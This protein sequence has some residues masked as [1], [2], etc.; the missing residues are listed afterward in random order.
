[1]AVVE[2]ARE[3]GASRPVRL[4]EAVGVLTAARQVVLLAH[5]NPDADALG[6]ALALGLALHRRGAEVQ[7]S[8]G[9][10][11]RPAESL[12]DLD[13]D[14]LVVTADE[15]V[16]AP[17]LLVVL[18]T[19]SVDRLGPLADRATTAGTTLVIDHHVS[20]AGFGTHY[21]VD[22]RAEATAV[23][24]LHLLDAMGAPV[25][26][27]TARCLYAG[28][29]TDTRNF[30]AASPDTHAMAAR[31]LV[32]G[33]DAEAVTRPLLDTH[34]F[35]WLA[36]LSAVLATARLEAGEARGLGLVH[37][38]VEREHV[39]SGRQEEVESVIDVLRTTAEAEVA[40]VLKQVGER[41][42]T[43]SMRSKGGI[44]VAAAASALGG[45][46]HRVASGFTLDGDAP[47]DPRACPARARRRPLCWDDHGSSRHRPRARGG[48]SRWRRRRWWSWSPSRSTCSS[49][50]P[51]SGTWAPSRWR[52]WPSAGSCWPRWRAW[53]RSS[54]TARPRAP[55]ATTAPGTGP[56]PSPRGWRRPGSRCSSGCSWWRVVWLAAPWVADLLGGGGAVSEAATGWLRIAVWGAPGILVA[57]AGHGWM[58]GVQYTRRPIVVVLAGNG[59]SAVMCPL[60]VYGIGPFPALGLEGSAWA[61]VGAQATVGLLFVGALV[62]ERVSLRPRVADMRAQFGLGRDLLLRSAAFQACFLS[63][64]AV[65]ARFGAPSVAAHQI[66]LQLWMFMVT[67]LD[68]L[69]IAAQS[70]VGAALGA[71]SV[72][73]ARRVSGR[74]TRYGLVLGVVAGLVFAATAGVLPGVFTPDPAVHG[75]SCRRPGGSSSRCSR[76][77]PTSSRSTG[78]CS[79]PA[80]RPT[81]AGSP[82]APRSARSCRRSGS[83]W[84]STGG[85]PAS[86]RAC[87]CSSSPAR[88]PSGCGSGARR[89]R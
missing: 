21:Y 62:L 49:T 44:D 52:V 85:S 84:C 64:T 58:R 67:V 29:V 70:L 1:M 26:L 77:P 13:V 19:G 35:S 43:A 15:V 7:V 69:A 38:L 28:L 74:V 23:M 16:A 10:P 40:V 4:E 31:L 65:A 55:R 82:S 47:R 68:A 73:V 27:P 8:F 83:R 86:G 14:G 54:P 88:W 12:R 63:A 46:G 3:G 72:G 79:A 33:V 50:R 59:L 53:A 39:D 76:S 87:R 24:V 30:R 34:P 41:R 11:E 61:N 20:N 66:V 89:G 75:T 71:A 25:D 37:A 45:G 48:S 57:L 36:M 60:L 78:C 80:T 9:A 42:W 5:V 22:P 6:S 17:E 32:A 18:D 81:C 56:P 2:D 51:S